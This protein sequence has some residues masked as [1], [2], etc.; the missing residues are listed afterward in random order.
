MVAYIYE[1]MS[2]NELQYLK[3]AFHLQRIKLGEGEGERVRATGGGEG[4][5]GRKE[6]GAFFYDGFE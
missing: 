4:G 1:I 3:I 2:K 5:G 6:V